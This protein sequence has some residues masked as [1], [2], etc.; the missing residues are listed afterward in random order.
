LLVLDDY[1]RTYNEQPATTPVK[2]AHVTHNAPIVP[3]PIQ[4]PTAPAYKYTPPPG[5]KNLKDVP[6]VRY[7]ARTPYRR[8]RAD[9]NPSSYLRRWG[10]SSLGAGMLPGRMQSVPRMT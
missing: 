7:S 4:T 3:R 1:V 8:Q 6:G 2:V 10:S 5:V 9:L